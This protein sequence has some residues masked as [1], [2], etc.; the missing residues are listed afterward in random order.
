MAPISI[1]VSS[2]E[3]S[4]GLENRKRCGGSAKLTKTATI[5]RDMLAAE[6]TDTEEIA[7]LIMLSAESA[8]RHEA[9]EAAHTL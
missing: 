2:R 9:S 6:G 8:G 5:G 4:S 3:L 7:E 1:A